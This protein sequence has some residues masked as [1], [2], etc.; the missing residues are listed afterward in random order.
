MWTIEISPRGRWL[1]ALRRGNQGEFKTMYISCGSDVGA[2]GIPV[3]QRRPPAVVNGFFSLHFEP[4]AY[5]GVLLLRYSIPSTAL[6]RV[7]ATQEICF[8]SQGVPQC[9]ACSRRTLAKL[10]DEFEPGDFSCP[11]VDVDF[12]DRD[13]RV[14]DNLLHACVELFCRDIVHVHHHLHLMGDFESDVQVVK[15]NRY[16]FHGMAAF[17]SSIVISHS[18]AALSMLPSVVATLQQ[19]TFP[20]AFFKRFH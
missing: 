7:I 11:Q 20:S 3:L 1:A 19:I 2:G 13:E 10:T 6:A 8:Y 15:D 14:T 16:M 4:I 18:R 5:E 12:H 9:S 17:R